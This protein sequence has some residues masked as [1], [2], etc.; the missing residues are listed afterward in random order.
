MDTHQ[1]VPSGHSRT[2]DATRLP[3]P[4]PLGARPRPGQHPL[5]AGREVRAIKHQERPVAIAPKMNPKARSASAKAG[6]FCLDRADA[7][8]GLAALALA[9]TT[10]Q[11]ARS[12]R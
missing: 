9:P 1:P 3:S 5:A 8:P 6:R 4:L 12:A 7:C 2:P 11:W 10:P